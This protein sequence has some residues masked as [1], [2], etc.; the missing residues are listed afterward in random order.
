MLLLGLTMLALCMHAQTIQNSA[1]NVLVVANAGSASW[2]A[3][4]VEH[5]FQMPLADGYSASTCG[6]NYQNQ[7]Q[8][9]LLSDQGDVIW[10]EE[11]FN[12]RFKQGSLMVE[13][14]GER[15][16]PEQVGKFTS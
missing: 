4:I 8:P 12:I 15:L 5:G 9:L 11:P 3:G 7:V 6:N 14:K 13:S 16:I 10:S 1:T 2:W